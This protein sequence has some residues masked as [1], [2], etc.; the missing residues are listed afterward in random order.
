MAL[1]T[2]TQPNPP[3][4]KSRK[5]HQWWLNNCYRYAFIMW[6]RAQCP[7]FILQQSLITYSP[8]QPEVPSEQSQY[9]SLSQQT[10]ANE[11]GQS[12]YGRQKK[13][14]NSS[15]ATLNPTQPNPTQPIEGPGPRSTLGPFLWTLLHGDSPTHYSTSWHRTIHS[16]RFS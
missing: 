16:H 11:L 12:K 14:H 2:L 10:A 13:S 5:Q 6:F 4:I 15:Y 1:L 9:I 3:V 8:E 7:M